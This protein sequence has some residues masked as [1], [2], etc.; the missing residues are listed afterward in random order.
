M[1]PLSFSFLP[2]L[3]AGGCALL[4]ASCQTTPRPGPAFIAKAGPR[5][6]LV[7]RETRFTFPYQ[8]GAFH[9]VRH[10]QYSPE[11]REISV[12]YN[13]DT[14]SI[15][16]T[17]YVY[18]S[19]GRSIEAEFVRLQ[20]EIKESHPGAKVLARAGTTLTP[21]KKPGI[22][23]DYRYEGKFA[24]TMQPLRSTLALGQRGDHFVEYRLSY[25]ATD[26]EAAAPLVRQ[27]E[28][29]FAWP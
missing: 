19:A 29:E 25:R 26:H 9:R 17:I 12:V 3:A 8:V 27:L 14:P 18:P 11:G 28:E 15:S 7:H 20:R 13:H 4:L 2:V 16:A 10:T 6:P 1:R 24:G 22:Y 23:A 21:D 5:G